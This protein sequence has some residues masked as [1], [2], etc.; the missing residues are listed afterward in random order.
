[1]FNASASNVK[2]V[3][4]RFGDIAETV[5]VSDSGPQQIELSVFS[6]RDAVPLKISVDSPE[7][8]AELLVS[9]DTRFLGVGITDIRN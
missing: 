4:F 8:P 7:S 6:N 9:D 1:V 3:D 2:K 5:Y